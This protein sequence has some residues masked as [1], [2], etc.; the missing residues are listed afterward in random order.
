MFNKNYTFYDYLQDE[1]L[2][3]KEYEF[4]KYDFLSRYHRPE[5][6]YV[7]T[8]KDNTIYDM[9]IKQENLKTRGDVGRLKRITE[10]DKVDMGDKDLSFVERLNFLKQYV[11]DKPYTTRDDIIFGK[12]TKD[13]F[14]GYKEGPFKEKMIQD[15]IEDGD[16]EIRYLKESLD[17]IKDMNDIDIK[18]PKTEID[19]TL[20]IED[21]DDYYYEHRNPNH[22]QGDIIDDEIQIEEKE[23]EDYISG[24][25]EEII[26]KFGLIDIH[27]GE[28]IKKVAKVQYKDVKS[29][30]G[31]LSLEQKEN[32]SIVKDL[33]KQVDDGSIEDPNNCIIS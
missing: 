27:Q 22:K 20:I 6:I 31:E 11:N 1:L 9:L 10:N 28:D 26:D 23:D 24:K 4:G 13:R 15:L 17:K 7:T 8:N 12:K 2:G 33:M 21:I 14:A 32:I 16:D 5:K 25:K 30:I 19:D 18:Y 3:S 29:K